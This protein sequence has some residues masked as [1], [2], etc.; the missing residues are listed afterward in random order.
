MKKLRTIIRAIIR[1]A[2][3]LFS[4]KAKRYI[5]Q[6]LPIV[7]VI[8]EM[9]PTRAD[10]EILAAYRRFGLEKL[11]DP[12]QDKAVLLRNLAVEV[13]RQKI[14]DPLP[15]RLLNLIVELAYNIYRERQSGGFREQHALEIVQ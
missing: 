8:A 5:D 12:A 2:R 6:A 14:R 3:R 7:Q 11:F 10:D 15:Q 9:T 4:P 13:V 1:F